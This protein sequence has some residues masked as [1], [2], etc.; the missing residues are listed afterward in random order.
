MSP[1]ERESRPGGYS[2]T[3]AKSTARTDH[4]LIRCRRRRLPL[5]ARRVASW[6]L[7]V[8]ESCGRSD[9]WHYEP[10]TTGYEAAALHLLEL[11]LTPAP[12]IPAMQAMWTAG[13][14]SRRAVQI[15]A[16]RWELAA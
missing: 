12:N 16:E 9:P 7:P 10:P 14:E 8:L 6:R 13:G 4:D 5:R 3:A 15:V 1:P 11:G 2:G